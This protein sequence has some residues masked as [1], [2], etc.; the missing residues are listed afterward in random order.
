MPNMRSKI[1]RIDTLND[2]DLRFRAERPMP[3]SDDD[4]PMEYVKSIQ[5]NV[6]QDEPGTQPYLF[7]DEQMKRA[8][9]GLKRLAACD[10]DYATEQNGGGFNGTDT[11]IGHS[12]AAQVRLTPK[13]GALAVKLCL[14]YKRQLGEDFVSCLK[15]N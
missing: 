5:V 11:G 13:Q 1:D 2:G 8:H 7:T 14:K 10:N 9:E 12:L 15:S 6:P 3:L 4:I